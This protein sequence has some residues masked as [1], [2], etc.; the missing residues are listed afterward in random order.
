MVKNNFLLIIGDGKPCFRQILDSLGF[1]IV[2]YLKQP[3]L[4]EE[5]R[6]LFWHFPHT[7]D[8]F[9][10]STVRKGDWKLIYRHLDQSLELYNI[11]T[12][13][14][15][16]SDLAGEEVRIKEE[17]ASLLSDYLREVNAGMPLLSETNK[18]VP[19]PDEVK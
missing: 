2:P 1:D 18:P 15:E 7:Y 4:R 14:S 5:D 8:Q 11:R 16:T 13:L 10:Y 12:D 19:Y 6:P 3:E 9:P 17:L